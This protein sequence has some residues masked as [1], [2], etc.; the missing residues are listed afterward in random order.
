MEHCFPVSLAPFEVA[1]LRL[2]R[3]GGEWQAIPVDMLERL[4]A[5]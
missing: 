5:H 3:R 1:S 2:A 4:P